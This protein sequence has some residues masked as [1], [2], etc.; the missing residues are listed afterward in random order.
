MSTGLF[1]KTIAGFTEYIKIA[2]TKVQN[3]MSQYG[4]SP[5]K[6]NSITSLY[7]VYIQTEAIAANPETATTGARRAR[8]ISR[9]A[10]ESAWRKFINEFIRYNSQVPVADLIIFGVKQRDT[11]PSKIGI[12]DIV[13]T[14]SIK[15]VGV[16]RYELEVFDSTTG[17]RKKP[18]YANGSYIYLA[19]T[20]LG[21]APE[22]ESE[23]RNMGFS[24]NCHHVLEFPVEQIAKQ[25]NIYACYSNSHGKE[26]PECS[27]ETIII[28]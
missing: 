2:Y 18:K 23:Y 26:G 1:P 28:G 9:K 19:V 13:P 14:L 4:I 25:A 3:S 8:D 15:Q 7:N 21:K 22:H 5:D 12:P 11:T 6:L 10:L 27:T 20:E 17:K 16:R 24:S